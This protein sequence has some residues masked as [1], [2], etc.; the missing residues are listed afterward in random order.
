MKQTHIALFWI[1]IDFMSGVNQLKEIISDVALIGDVIGTSSVY[2]KFIN[3]RSED[4]NS[5][6]SIVV[7]IET[8]K[9]QDEIFERIKEILKQRHLHRRE[10]TENLVLLAFNQDVRLFPGENLPSPTLHTNPLDILMVFKKL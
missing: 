9:N 5:E 3:R 2:K 8:E 6:L 4:L 1:S 7:K 10:N